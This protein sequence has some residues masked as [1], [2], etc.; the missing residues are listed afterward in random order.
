MKKYFPLLALTCLVTLSICIYQM[1]KK[2]AQCS[3][4]QIALIDPGKIENMRT[5]IKKMTLCA[6]SL[7]QPN[8]S[9]EMKYVTDVIMFSKDFSIKLRDGKISWKNILDSINTSNTYNT[10]IVLDAD[11]CN[12]LCMTNEENLITIEFCDSIAC[13]VKE[14]DFDELPNNP[15]SI[16][17]PNRSYG[18]QKVAQLQ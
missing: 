10:V 1:K 7:Q 13:S 9:I 17:K 8:T 6:D 3:N 12:K 11:I 4:Y 14:I 16:R 18:P 15:D 2:P 5:Y